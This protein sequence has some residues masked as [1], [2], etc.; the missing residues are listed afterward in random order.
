MNI[1]LSEILAC[2]V[3][4]GA[5]II[6]IISHDSLRIHA[7]CI[8]LSQNNEI[9]RTLYLWNRVEG[10]RYYSG[11][12]EKVVKSN[13]NSL[14]EVLDWFLG[15]QDDG[16]SIEDDN[17]SS[18]TPTDSILLL[19]D[20]HYELEGQ[21]PNLFSKLR[22]YA[23]RKGQ[24]LYSDRSLIFS[25][26]IPQLPVELEKDTQVFHL[27]LPDRNALMVLL[28]ATKDQYHIDERDFQASS[29]LIDAALGLSTSEAQLA[30]AKAAVMKRRLTESEIDLVVAEKEQVI[31]KSGLLE[32]F[33]PQ[34]G[35]DDV[36]GLK[37]LKNW[38]ER[39]KNAYTE[40][41]REF[42]LEYPK[43]VLMLGLPGTGKS[44]AAKAVSSNWQLPLLRLDMGK[45]FGGV[46]G[47]SEENIR[48]ALQMAETIAPCILW[49]DE[50]EKG[51][52]GMQSSGSSDGGT[53]ARVLGTFLT[54]MQEKTSPVFVLATANN[55][56]MLPPELL[57]K[58][59]VDEIFFVDL[60]VLEERIEI[61]TIHLKKRDDRHE[62][63]TDSELQKLGA[64]SRGFTGAELEEAVK[65][66]LFMAFSEHSEVTY[67]QISEA[68]KST[69]PL[70][71][72]MHE[73]ISDTRKWIDG[74]AVSASDAKPEPLIGDKI[75]Q[76]PRL[77][78]ES[79]NPFVKR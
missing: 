58:G 6:Q 71:V 46:V 10:L 5:P 62:L 63:F 60:P 42:G 20:P 35:L 54:W 39:R 18:N 34:V 51:L 43:G 15:I 66:A 53:T 16:F 9:N 48:N 57:R 2:N 1:N 50:I 47:Q 4:A 61:L 26:P 40:D 72:T 27:S 23:L 75:S 13:M 73:T 7:E 69:S 44:L 55:I 36:G 56:E 45:V 37:N 12:L 17:A 8:E 14:D 3:K 59:R 24:G 21:N 32:Y 25:Q 22:L 65:E 52:S 49:I 28:N 41:A 70:S 19:E 38:L 33:H 79:R 64:L 30:F 76:S 74:R 29:R 67:L 31:K 78:Q 77:Q 11:S 68:I